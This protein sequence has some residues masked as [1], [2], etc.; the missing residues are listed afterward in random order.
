MLTRTC[1]IKLINETNSAVG[2]YQSTCCQCQPIRMLS[3]NKI[4]GDN[5]YNSN[6]LLELSFHAYKINPD[7]NPNPNRHNPKNL[8]DTIIF[9]GY[10]VR[11]ECH[12]PF[13]CHWMP[14]YIESIVVRADA[15]HLTPVMETKQEY[16]FLIYL[17][18]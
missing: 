1:L 18:N 2:K 3:S 14:L 11:I 4:T 6:N 15:E 9:L 8:L 5:V 7:P 17:K 12:C 16:V 10:N 13:F